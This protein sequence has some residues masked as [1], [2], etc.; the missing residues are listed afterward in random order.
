M[1]SQLQ[2]KHRGDKLIWNLF[3]VP[4]LEKDTLGVELVFQ[5]IK[6][7]YPVIGLNLSLKPAGSL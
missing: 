6:D 1:I 2:W 7:I 3:T 5:K 4:P